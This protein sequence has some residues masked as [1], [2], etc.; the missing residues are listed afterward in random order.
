MKGRKDIAAIKIAMPQ[1][2]LNVAGRALMLHGALGV[3]NEMPF[4]RQIINSY[5]LGLADGPT[6]VHKLTLARQILRGYSPSDDLFPTRHGLKL[7]E[8]ALRKFGQLVGPTDD[9][10]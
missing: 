5:F 7:R 9:Q 8:K 10:I 6:E 1:V 4:A 2:L 3:S